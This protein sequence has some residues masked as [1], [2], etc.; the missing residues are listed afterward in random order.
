VREPGFTLIEMVVT[1]ILV[2]I[3]AF[4][5]IPRGPDTTPSLAAQGEQ[6]V[7]DLRYVQSRAMALGVRHRLCLAAAGYTIATTSCATP[8]AH[9]ATGDT[10]PVGFGGITL[11]WAGLPNNYVAFDSAGVPYITDPGTALSANA[12][13]TLTSNQ[14]GSQMVTISPETGRA[15]SP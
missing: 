7:S 2:A 12:T 13:I 10:A 11:S 9:P 14:G 6:L 5:A 4:T 3:I 15:V 8:I 1:L